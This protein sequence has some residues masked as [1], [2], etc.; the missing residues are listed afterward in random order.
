MRKVLGKSND[1]EPKSTNPEEKYQQEAYYKDGQ[2][3]ILSF[4]PNNKKIYYFVV[5]SSTKYSAVKDIL[6]V[7]NL[8]SLQTKTYLAEPESSFNST[9]YNSV[10]IN[11]K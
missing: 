8:D 5:V 9:A 10:R 7:A 1:S 11:L 3:L 2:S 6:K 4:N